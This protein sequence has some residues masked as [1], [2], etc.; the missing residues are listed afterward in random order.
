MQI[1]KKNYIFKIIY[2]KTGFT[3]I[4]SLLLIKLY[5]KPTFFSKKQLYIYK[6]VIKI[7][8]SIIVLTLLLYIIKFI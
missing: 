8:I 6:I 7:L 2:K 4:F 5:K 3:N 1:Q